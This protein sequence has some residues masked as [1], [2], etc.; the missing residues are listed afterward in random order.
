MLAAIIIPSEF[1]NGRESGCVFLPLDDSFHFYELSV[2]RGHAKIHPSPLF[3]YAMRVAE[4][5][6]AFPLYYDTDD[7]LLKVRIV[8]DPVQGRDSI[9]PIYMFEPNIFFIQ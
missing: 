8:H 6:A 3:E 2:E 1:V 9:E 4:G 5:Y 7:D